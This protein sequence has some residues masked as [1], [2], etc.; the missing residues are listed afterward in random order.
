MA[1]RT[2]V[3]SV[4]VRWEAFDVA[5]V[6]PAKGRFTGA[7]ERRS[8]WLV[9]ESDEGVK[10]RLSP[11]PENWL[12]CSDFEIERW[13]MKGVTAP[14]APTRRAEDRRAWPGE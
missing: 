10:R 3:D 14:P 2:F 5:P 11:V 12:T 13:C 4:G 9:F 8:P 1:K 6:S 7:N